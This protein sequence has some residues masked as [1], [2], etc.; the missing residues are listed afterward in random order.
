MKIKKLTIT[1][2]ELYLA[3]EA[4]LKTQGV[5]CPVE[6]VDKEYSHRTEWNVEFKEEPAPIPKLEIKT[7]TV[8]LSEVS[9]V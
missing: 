3:V 9:T 6:S 7:T 5:S 2:A 8:E 1:D 4:Y